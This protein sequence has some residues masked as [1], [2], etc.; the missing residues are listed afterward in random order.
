MILFV[1]IAERLNLENYFFACE[2]VQV[3]WRKLV[4]LNNKLSIREQ[5]ELDCHKVLFGTAMY[6]KVIN[7]IIL[8]AK[9]FIVTQ[10]YQD[11]IIQY[12]KFLSVVIRNFEMEKLIARSDV[13]KAKSR[14]RWTPFITNRGDIDVCNISDHRMQVMMTTYDVGSLPMMCK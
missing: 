12:E 3:F 2:K 4:E 13:G 9:Q 6:S 1:I 5:I 8:L 7:F 10:Q 14:N 11:A